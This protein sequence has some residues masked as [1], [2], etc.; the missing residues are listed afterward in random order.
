MKEKEFP[1]FMGK[2]I[3]L[4][5]NV[6][7]Q[8]VTRKSD[9]RKFI[10]LP[11]H[12][13]TQ[14]LNWVPPL[15]DDEW[16]LHDPRRNEALSYSEVVRYIAW[17]GGS[18]VG[19][20]MGIINHTYNDFHNEKTARFFNLDCIDD[21]SVASA[22]L[23]KVRDWALSKHMNQLIG[24]YGFS[25]KDPQGLQIEGLQHLPVI[26][27]PSNPPY[28]QKLIEYE[29]FTK[30]IDCVTYR[31]PLGDQMPPSYERI[32]E[33]QKRNQNFRV[34]EFRTKRQ[35]KRYIVPVF[36]I[37]NATY[38]NLFGFVPMS[39]AE[40]YKFAA[41]YLP[42]LDPAFVKVIVNKSNDVIAFIVGMP[43]MSPGLQR[44]KGKLFPFGFIH[45][46]RS[47]KRTRQ[48]NLL[49]GAVAERYRGSGLTVLLAKSLF[50]TARIRNLEYV[51]SHLILETNRQ[52]RSAC[53]SAEGV[54]Y[55]RY[56]IYQKSLS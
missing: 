11:A 15:Y 56:R 42:V 37:V 34:I 9:L 22:L 41:Q 50:T 38:A 31:L 30:R 48:L 55:K 43:D 44:A 54:V 51:D 46:L 39:E 47:M 52:M 6:R 19:R 2:V 29:G 4:R 35:L 23:N 25:D 12:L 3:R 26:A 27:T 45:I 10:Y 14:W 33:R 1:F 21:Q 40:I 32:Y 5:M 53:E 13:Y 36:R 49:L 17:S 18:P 8:E 7:M 28:V 16:K 20:I 24:P